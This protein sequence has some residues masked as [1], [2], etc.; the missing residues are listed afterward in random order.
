MTFYNNIKIKYVNKKYQ[1]KIKNIEKIS[2]DKFYIFKTK[3][4]RLWKKITTR[5]F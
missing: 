3:I 4:K 2:I 1:K 5:S